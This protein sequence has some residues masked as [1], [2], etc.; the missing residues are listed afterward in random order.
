MIIGLVIL[1][2]SCSQQSAEIKPEQDSFGPQA[3][4]WVQLG[5]ANLGLEGGPLYY[6][7]LTVYKDKVYVIVGNYVR[8]WT[9]TAWR[10]LTMVSGEY[11]QLTTNNSGDVFV[12]ERKNNQIAVR[13]WN[14]QT[15]QQLGTVI[16]QGDK[17]FTG[18]YLMYVNSKG[19]LIVT[20]LSEDRLSY[21]YTTRVRQWDGKTWQFVG[22]PGI[23][24]GGSQTSIYLADFSVDSSDR[25]YIFTSFS[26]GG[27]YRGY[28][29][30]RWK[31]T[32]WQDLGRGACY[33]DIN[34]GRYVYAHFEL[35][36]N[37]PNVVCQ[38]TN[39]KTDAGNYIDILKWNGSS[40]AKSI[41]TINYKKGEF[42]FVSGAQGSSLLHL[43][44]SRPDGKILVSRL[45]N[46]KLEAFGTSL[47]G[48]QGYIATSSTT[49]PV[50]GYYLN[51]KVYISC[52][53]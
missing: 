6:S 33:S 35:I 1:L 25:P 38:Y 43:V 3:Q 50:I 46:G 24:G 21:T 53:Q 40:W 13:R 44:N 22:T 52:W 49:G 32:A 39:T 23:V 16:P 10:N 19:N 34:E 4:T 8:Y 7:D 47:S 2:A 12:S 51:D 5:G 37:T 18:D 20:Y 29:V 17:N 36:S 14:G 26:T 27:E 9:G 42:G 28:S 15:W 45:V 41:S 48:Y 30:I 11:P 31:D